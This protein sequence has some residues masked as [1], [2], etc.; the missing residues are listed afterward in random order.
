LCS[1][2]SWRVSKKTNYSL[3]SAVNSK[4]PKEAGKKPN[5]RIHWESRKK[6]KQTSVP[7]VVDPLPADT[8]DFY[9]FR[10]LQNT[11]IMVC[12]GCGRKFR[13]SITEVPEPPNDLVLARKE[14]RKCV[15][16]FGQLK[17]SLKKEFVH[18]HIKQECVK[19]KDSAFDPHN[20]IVTGHIRS[21]LQD[22]HKDMIRHHWTHQIRHH[23][24]HQIRPSRYSQGHDQTK[25]AASSVSIYYSK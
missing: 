7:C 1:F 20:I 6:T 3:T 8:E 13:N 17:M 16:N 25:Y 12:Y 23:W 15:N 18:Y 21:D 19:S 10:F 4:L 24:T 9:I 14:Y 22:I 2:I 5:E 11:K